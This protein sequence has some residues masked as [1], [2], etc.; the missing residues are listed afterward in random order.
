MFPKS[1]L[2]IDD[3]PPIRA[4]I[5]ASLE[6]LGGWRVLLAG[7]GQEGLIKAAIAQPDAILLD[8]MMPEMDG[9]AVVQDLRADPGTHAIPV[10]LLTATSHLV[11][12]QQLLDLNISLVISKP[13]Q[14]QHLVHQ[15]S[16][17]LNWRVDS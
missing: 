4:A 11:N 7:S 3:E 1:I 15:I 14:P 10:I 5:P 17:I 16:T 8:V 2:I 13:F 12:S 9:L 6:M